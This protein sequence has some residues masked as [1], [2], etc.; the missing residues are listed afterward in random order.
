LEEVNHYKEGL[1]NVDNRLENLAKE[2]VKIR[3]DYLPKKW[4]LKGQ[5][6]DL[7]IQGMTQR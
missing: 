4:M 5:T 1:Q 7:T 2:I 3:Q 6:W